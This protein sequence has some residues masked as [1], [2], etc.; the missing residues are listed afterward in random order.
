ML[1]L[2]LLVLLL[3]S[4]I[5]VVHSTWVDFIRI[6]GTTTSPGVGLRVV[7]SH[8]H[9]TMTMMM[10][11]IGSR[12]DSRVQRWKLR[13]PQH[14]NSRGREEGSVCTRGGKPTLT[15]RSLCVHIPTLFLITPHILDL[16][17]ILL[18]ARI[19]SQRFLH[20][21]PILSAILDTPPT[22]W[23]HSPSSP[24]SSSSLVLAYH[25]GLTGERGILHAERWPRPILS[26][27]CGRMRWRGYHLQLLDGNTNCTINNF[28]STHG[29]LGN[30]W[31]GRKE[32]KCNSWH[33]SYQSQGGQN[34]PW[35]RHHIRNLA[36]VT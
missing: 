5:V 3:L 2:L 20:L 34:R 36:P 24:S 16:V 23:P 14:F 12:I 28:A 6:P 32:L 8:S 19:S 27:P 7:E 15:F 11:M 13:R 1:L 26:W 18:L 33:M 22:R 25:V 35:H 29:I 4:V 17:P 10:M 21:V 30:K 31:R 9:I